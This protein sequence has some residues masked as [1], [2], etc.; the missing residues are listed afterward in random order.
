M[1]GQRPDEVE[2]P[3]PAEVCTIGGDACASEG[4]P[5]QVCVPGGI[6]T[7]GNDDD[8]LLSTSPEHEVYVSPFWMDRTPATVASYRACMDEGA[9]LIRE[10]TENPRTELRSYV[11]DPER[12][13][14]PMWGLTLQEILEYCTHHGGGLPSDAQ[15]ERAAR[16]DDGRTYPWGEETGCEYANWGGCADTPCE[17]GAGAPCAGPW[18]AVDAYPLGASPYGILDLLGN[19]AEVARDGWASD[20]YDG[21]WPDLNVCDPGRPDRVTAASWCTAFT[22]FSS[23]G[24]RTWRGCYPASDMERCTASFRF[25]SPLSWSMTDACQESEPALS[26]PFRCVRSGR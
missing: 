25:G 13:N 17:P 14:Y 15:Y 4:G 26:G 10:N 24:V 11:M 5:D 9:C 18:T 16:G 8:G 22:N 12:A 21:Y 20:G 1:P 6:F 2:W 19:G 7:I 3:D 23:I